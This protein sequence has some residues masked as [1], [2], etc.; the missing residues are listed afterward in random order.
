MYSSTLSLTS[1]LDGVSGKRHPPTSLPP[2]MTRYPLY[3]RLGGPQGGYGQMRKISQPPPPGVRSPDQPVCSDLLYRLRYPG[4]RWKVV[5]AFS[6]RPPFLSRS[7]T[8]S[9]LPI[10]TPSYGQRFLS[11]VYIRCLTFSCSTNCLYAS[12]SIPFSSS[13]SSQPYSQDIV[14]RNTVASTVTRLRT[15]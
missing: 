12:E 5:L 8:A 4:P 15:R 2:G 9:T 10:G 3:R 1:A 11:V 14:N 7:T 13:S 6:S